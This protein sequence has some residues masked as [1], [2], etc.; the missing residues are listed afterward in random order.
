MRYPSL[1]GEAGLLQRP[2]AVVPLL[3]RSLVPEDVSVNR[4]IPYGATNFGGWTQVQSSV[5]RH[6]LLRTVPNLI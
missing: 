6:C 5:C 1:D 4:Y 2:D 3:L